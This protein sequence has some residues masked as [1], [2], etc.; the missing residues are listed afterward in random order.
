M[1]INIKRYTAK[2]AE[3]SVSLMI[4]RKNINTNI[5]DIVLTTWKGYVADLV[6]VSAIMTIPNTVTNVE[7]SVLLMVV[8]KNDWNKQIIVPTTPL[9]SAYMMIVK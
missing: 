7:F 5:K 9:R 1:R 2:L 6:V 3:T 4:V 8:M